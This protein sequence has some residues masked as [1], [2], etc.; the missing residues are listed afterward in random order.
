MAIVTVLNPRYKDDR[1]DLAA[2]YYRHPTGAFE[3]S[4]TCRDPQGV[5]APRR[6]G[7]VEAMRKAYSSGQVFTG[8][9][10][11]IPMIDLRPYLEP[12]LNMHNARQAF[13]VRARLLDAGRA[14]AARQ[15]IWFTRSEADMQRRVLEA[16]S[17][18]DRLLS[19]GPAPAEFTDRCVDAGGAVN[20]AGPSAGDGILDAGPP[21][22][23][24]R[25]FPLFSSPRMVAG[26]SIKGDVFK[27]A[28]KPVTQALR[29]GSYP[30]GEAWTAPQQAW[31]RRIFPHGVCDY[32]QPD[33]GRPPALERNR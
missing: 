6:S 32:S 16:L 8:W 20:A 28:L 1:Y 25:P 31:L 13:S 24:T 17:V 30:A 7:S 23:C 18:M 10:L 14:E 21:G 27:C 11:G 4:A 19:G 26:E 33:Q 3:R 22:A 5:P 15:V 29:D 12:E 2:T 9:R